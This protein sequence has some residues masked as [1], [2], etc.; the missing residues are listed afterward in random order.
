MA[1]EL[2]DIPHNMQRLCRR[3][4]PWRSAHT[5]RL[6]IPERLWAAA[7]ELAQ[8][9]VLG[10]LRFREAEVAGLSRQLDECP[11]EGEAP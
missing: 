9:P 8:T 4:E 1:S 3:F 6:P 7:A 11:A 2:A 5:G 10:G